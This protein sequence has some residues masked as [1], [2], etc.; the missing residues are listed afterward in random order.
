MSSYMPSYETTI[1]FEGDTISIEIEPLS[2]EDFE[3][4]LPFFKEDVDGKIQMSFEDKAKFN[5]VGLDV[6]GRYVVRFEGLKDGKGQPVSLETVLTKTYF[7]K[8]AAE[9]FSLTFLASGVTE[10][11]EKK[12]EG[13]S[14]PASL[15]SNLG[16]T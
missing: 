2:N 9:L 15:E 6:V 4:L 14:T 10:A 16:P 11:E 7:I 5:K 8:L 13:P 12:S 1:E 3:K